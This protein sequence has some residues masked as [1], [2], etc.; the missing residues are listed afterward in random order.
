MSSDHA[1]T[2]FGAAIDRLELIVGRLEAG[3]ALELEEALSLFEQGLEL[4]SHCR[5]Q[6]A[7]AQLKLTALAGIS[8]SAETDDPETEGA[9]TPTA[10]PLREATVDAQ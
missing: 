2:T 10:R 9:E 6:L 4:A 8:A 7:T 1:V 5:E 3:D